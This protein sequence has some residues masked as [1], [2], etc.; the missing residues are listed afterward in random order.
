MNADRSRTSKRMPMAALLGLTI[1]L[2]LC[3][4]S[5]MA[6]EKGAVTF[7]GGKGT[8]GGKFS[9]FGGN[10]QGIA[11]NQTGAGGVGAGDIYIPDKYNNRIQELTASGEFVRAFGLD[12]G[13]SGVDVCTVAASCQAGT[14]S[15]AAGSVLFPK[16][17][18]ID[19]TNGT[20]YVAGTYS[21]GAG[22]FRIDVFS[23]TGEFEGAFGWNVKATGGAEELQL[24]TAE[25]GCKAGSKGAGLGQFR[26]D[27]YGE[28]MSGIAVSPLNGHVFVGDRG[29][30]R[31]DE[32]AP[33]FEEGKVTGISYVRHF[34]LGAPVAVDQSGKVY[35]TGNT[36]TEG[37]TDHATVETYSPEGVAE[38]VLVTY[39]SQSGFR[40]LA[41]DSANGDILALDFSSLYVFGPSGEPLD[42]Y[43]EGASTS[44]FIWG[45]AVSE[46]TETIYLTTS[47]PEPGIL[48]LGEIVPPTASI[49]PVGAFT[50]TTAT[51]EG[52]VNPEGFFAKYRFEYSTD[53]VH[54]T[55]LAYKQLPN[56]SEEHAV[57]QEATGLEAHT[58]YQ[59]RLVAEKLLNGGRAEAQTSF[60]TIAAAPVLSAPTVEGIAD[61][62]AKLVATLNPE[63]EATSYRFE[64]VSQAQFEA[65]GY[66]EATE[67]PSG[68]A[69][70]EAGG[71][72]VEVS[73]EISG[74]SPESEYRCRIA[75]SNATGGATSPDTSFATYASQPL[76]PPDSRSY[77]QVSPVAKNGSDARGGAF[78][79]R[80]APDGE[81]ASYLIA[82]DGAGEEDGGAQHLGI[83][84][85]L[86]EGGSWSSHTLWSPARFGNFASIVGWSRDLRR[87]YVV[88]NFSGLPATLYEQDLETGAM[89][90]IASGI[91]YGST[92]FASETADGSTVLFESEEA[93]ATGATAGWN[94]L[95]LWNRGTHKLSL[96]D[97]GP[98]GTPPFHG[99]F[100]GPWDWANGNPKAGGAETGYYTQQL[101]ALSE[102]GTTAFFTSYNVNQLYARSG[103][104]TAHPETAQVSASQKTNG[105]GAGGKDPHGPQK[106]AFMEATPDGRY[107]FFAS[108]EELT[109]D[110]T[111]GSEDQ[112]NDL[113]RYDTQTGE[114]IDIAPDTTDANGAEVQGVLGASADASYVYFAANGALTEG[115]S[116]GNCTPSGGTC[117]IYVWHE[118]EIS[119]VASTAG[120]I[121]TG[122][123]NW[124]P[125]NSTGNSYLKMRTGG[126]SPNGALLFN[127]RLSPTSYDSEGKQE[128]YRYE[129]GSGIG[130]VSCNPTG[131]PPLG[132]ASLQHIP[133][134]YL[135]AQTPN[136]YWVRSLSADG[137][138]AFFETPDQLVATDNNGNAGCPVIPN[139]GG[140][141]TCQDV[142]EWEAKGSGSCDSE[143]QNGGCIYLISTGES[144]E[145]SYF[146]DAG[147][148]GNDVFFFTRQ[149]LVLQ[150]EDNLQDLYDARVNG[151]LA[152][153]NEEP[154]SKCEGESCRGPASTP[155]PS[156]SAGSVSFSGPANPKPSHAHKKKRHAKKH[157]KH[158]HHRH[159]G[160]KRHG[161]RHGTRRH[162][163]KG[164]AGR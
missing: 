49:D 138:R 101:H 5:A 89:T 3:S 15:E 32:L 87:D 69:S 65:S 64:C 54:W 71:E 2:A 13:G 93:L 119:F 86:R 12:V 88:S 7:Y 103:L 131:A 17:V 85:A 22:N 128:V 80:A 11:V 81:A 94:N 61:T 78:R 115:S 90:A 161:K 145:P 92:A 154:K 96:I 52:H 72:A 38:G 157:R 24:C 148:S 144:D 62:T 121:E 21:A 135:S 107:V 146:A 29:N 152:S 44:A 132:G 73:T 117:S 159:K 68:G 74:L 23:A 158:A 153:Q 127:S 84:S 77:E 149:S 130:C 35:V 150:D 30:A 109:N 16:F 147:E 156:E 20:L 125:T 57:S 6:A 1:L 59:V 27:Q 55:A 50:G 108:S 110:A 66:A 162:A 41:V 136:P 104:D 91:P 53:G 10:A 56:D 28:Y 160:R 26:A 8:E 43:L 76:G 95:Y 97:I 113:Y 25:S 112:G 19:Q 63:N 67:V 105:S 123:L 31:E 155:P 163:S 14:A 139:T 51:F 129:P 82:A 99:A 98:S 40:A 42:T 137:K 34:G 164:R 60:E 151:G 116:A 102:D 70:L 143:G 75:A 133:T 48:V 9:T 124:I 39:A 18:A 36:T 33:S 37:S 126:V 79:L 47:Q 100:A 111:T 58:H 46:E 142:Y 134:G 141:R 45:V 114:L 4:G 118:G 83:Y 122:G 106:A 120:S 140:V